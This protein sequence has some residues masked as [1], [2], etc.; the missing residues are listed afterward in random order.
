MSVTLPLAKVL[1]VVW[2]PPIFKYNLKPTFGMVSLSIT[3]SIIKN[4]IRQQWTKITRIELCC[5]NLFMKDIDGTILFR[6]ELW[7]LVA[8]SH[9]IYE[10]ARLCD[11]TQLY[12][13][14]SH[15][16]SVSVPQ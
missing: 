8:L 4:E 3:I 16:S 6:I 1:P 9:F 5:D 12:L 14:N 13:I 15:H 11:E 10:L 7:Y 2:L